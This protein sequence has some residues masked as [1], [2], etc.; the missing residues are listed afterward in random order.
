ME[1]AQVVELEL[2][3]IR[4]HPQKDRGDHNA[5]SGSDGLQACCDV[6]AMSINIVQIEDNRLPMNTDAK[7][8]AALGRL[9][10]LK[11]SDFPLQLRGAAEGI[12]RALEHRNETIACI[13]N[14]LASS[15][16]QGGVYYADTKG[17][18][19]TVR[20]D[21]R[22]FHEPSIADHVSHKNSS[23]RSFELGDSAY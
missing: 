6:D 2:A 22:S 3:Q 23:E 21:L 20:L 12:C 11:P 13:F 7:S 4:G 10:S 19:T 15:T 1:F 8:D 17:P 18:I 16:N 14:N 9:L 5:T